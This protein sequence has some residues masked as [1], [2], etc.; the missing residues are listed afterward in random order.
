MRSAGYNQC[1][2]SVRQ[3]VNDEL[4]YVTLV[5]EPFIARKRT[6]DKQ[7]ATRALNGITILCRIHLGDEIYERS[8][9][10]DRSS[11]TY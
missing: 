4:N 6:S 8:M 1:S 11:S 10:K 5:C 7:S 2:Y 3:S 9:F